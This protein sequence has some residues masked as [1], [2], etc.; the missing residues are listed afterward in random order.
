MPSALENR[1]TTHTINVM[2][3]SRARRLKAEKP[4]SLGGSL[5]N[6]PGQAKSK[7]QF[8]ES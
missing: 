4:A 1:H 7:L 5:R 2:H 3:D 8:V 6:A